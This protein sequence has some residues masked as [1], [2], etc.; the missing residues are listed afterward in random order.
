MKNLCKAAL[1]G[2][3][4]GLT[5]CASGPAYKDTSI[6]PL[7]SDQGRIF[8]YR[9]SSLGAAVQPDLTLNGEVVGSAVPDGFFYVDRAPGNYEVVAA[10]EVKNKLT[11]TLEK[12]QLRYV[13]LDMAMGLLVG[14]VIPRLADETTG[15]KEIVD[16]KF[17]DPNKK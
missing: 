6:A 7:R 10:T 1:L 12:G 14:H 9:P 5:A 4:L 15:A 3:V 2:L 16:T 11:F 8:F 13:R 17:A